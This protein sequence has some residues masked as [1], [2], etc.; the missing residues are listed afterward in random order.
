LNT[1]QDKLRNFFQL[2]V[3]LWGLLAVA[4]SLACVL[5]LTAFLGQFWW[6]FDLTSHFRV[7][8]AGGLL[9]LALVFSGARRWKTALLFTGFAIVNCA[10]VVP[11]CYSGGALTSSAKQTLRILVLNVHTENRQF[12][13]VEAFIRE[14]NP[15][16]IVLE[17]INEEWLR[18][19]AGLQA[20]Y[21][22]GQQEPREDNFGIALFSKAPLEKSE[23]V[24]LGQAGVPSVTATVQFAGKSLRILGT[25]PLPPSGGENSRLRNQQLESIPAFLS[26]GRG[27]TVIV[28]DLNAT[29][30]SAHFQKL[31]RDTGLIDSGRGR[32][33]QTTWPSVL[34]PLGIAIDHCLVSPDLKVVSRKV[35]RNVGSDH[36]PLVIEIAVE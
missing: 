21:P 5:T 19:L 6:A 35:G 4:G 28:G 7:H 8:Y 29:P 33:L 9:L 34:C 14:I 23:I 10:I 16:M 30:W 12:Q 31:L 1:K 18:N 15:D 26:A 13:S 20:A 3:D 2:K 32:G 36:L 25:H 27:P 24:Y 17:E 22:H 11:Y